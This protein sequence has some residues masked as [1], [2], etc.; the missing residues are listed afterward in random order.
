MAGEQ[1]EKKL[2]KSLN[3]FK[4]DFAHRSFYFLGSSIFNLLPLSLRNIDS[5]VLF[6]T[7]L[8]DF[9]TLIT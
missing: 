8:D 7:A 5:R 4:L 9:Y 2:N 3:V 1:Q 6:R